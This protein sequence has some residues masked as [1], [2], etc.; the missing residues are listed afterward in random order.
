M[1]LRRTI[2]AFT[3]EYS[4]A[5]PFQLSD[6]EWIQSGF[7][8][9]VTQFFAFC[10]TNISKS[11]GSSI[12]YVYG[13]YD[14]LFEHLHESVRRLEPFAT[15]YSWVPNLIYGVESATEKLD[16]YYNACYNDLGSLYA[17]GTILWPQA[18]LSSFDPKYCWL[19]PN[20]RDW[21][22]TFENQFH[23]V[24]RR[25]YSNLE[26]QSVRVSRPINKDPIALLLHRSRSRRDFG[27][28]CSSP[29]YRRDHQEDED[30]SIWEV[31]HYLDSGML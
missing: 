23:R 1:R 19:D 4:K 16:K 17:F 3:Q 31:Q 12:Q 21:K 15:Q 13:L 8:I 24:F 20:R 2:T 10:T 11:R 6:S 25:D 26:V 27:G 9:D 29:A 22:N 28:Q 5:N 7:L 30:N 18:K 14:E